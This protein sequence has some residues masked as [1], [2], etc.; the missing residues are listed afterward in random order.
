MSIPVPKLERITLNGIDVTNYRY[1]GL[2]NKPWRQPVKY[3]TFR[4]NKN[5]NNT[6][7]VDETI[8]GKSFTW[9]RGFTSPTERYIFR[10]EVLSYSKLGSQIELGVAD[11]AFILTRREQDYTY[12]QN[13]DVQAGIGSE[14]IKDLATIEDLQVN[15]NSVPSTGTTTNAL[16]KTYPA[17][18]S[19]LENIQDLANTY[20]RIVYY[21]DSDDLLYCT[22]LTFENASITLTIGQNVINRVKWES[23]GQDMIN[24]ATLI[25]G[26]QLDWNSETFTADVGQTTFSV[27]A[28]PVDSEV[29]K[30]TI[31]QNRGVD[32]SDPQ[33]FYVKADSKDFIF[34]NPMTG[35][36]TIIIAY[37]YNIPAKVSSQDSI[38][39][40]TYKQR[41]KTITSDKILNSDD[42]EVKINAFLEE[43]SNPLTNAPLRVVGDNT[44]E[45]GQL[46]PVI[47]SQNAK[48]ESLLINGITYYS[49][50]RPDAI[51]VGKKPI[52]DFDLQIAILNNLTRLNRQLA[53][54]SEVNVHIIPVPKTTIAIGYHKTERAT[55]EADSLYFDSEAQGNWDEENWASETEET[56]TVSELIPLNNTYFDDFWTTE[57]KDVSNTTATWTAGAGQIT[58]TDGQIAQSD[59]IL[60]DSLITQVHATLKAIYEGSISF[61]ISL[62]GTNWESVS[63]NIEKT[64]INPGN[65]VYWRA[66]SAGISTLYSV[67]IRPRSM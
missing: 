52:S 12:D 58:F 15:D 65:Y 49:P 63:E 11:K 67:E 61:E 25:G 59:Y 16:I 44:L 17:K 14:I 10:G 27:S 23:T 56:Y 38:S 30:N 8:I 50:Y 40:D 64:F 19:R 20:V 31:L 41:D 46:V 9:Q 45:V 5:I 53:S 22:P 36:E 33:D 29:Y 35:G 32:S 54:N 4:F 66:T 6:L 18:G 24:N 28:I 26:E 57:F 42:A 34:T 60:K 7:I 37:S 43:S 3:A 1:D 39:I 62:D 55:S 47:D 48:N 21:R 51:N 2:A 13:T